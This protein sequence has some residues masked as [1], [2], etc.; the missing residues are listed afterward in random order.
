MSCMFQL[1]CY[2]ES[3]SESE[4]FLRADCALMAARRAARSFWYA[5][6]FAAEQR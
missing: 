3:E 2:E 4:S 1:K 6:I 5:F